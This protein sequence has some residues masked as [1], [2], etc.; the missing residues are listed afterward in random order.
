MGEAEM[1]EIAGIIKMVL[2]GTRAGTVSDGPNA[3]KPSKR[4]HVLDEQVREEARARTQALLVR[5]PVYPALDLAF[6][7]E[8]FG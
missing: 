7:Q 1:R 2:A 6:L 3:G 8:H 5:F 4:R